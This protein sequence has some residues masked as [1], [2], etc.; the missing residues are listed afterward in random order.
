M[1]WLLISNYW[2]QSGY[3]IYDL[4]RDVAEGLEE[5]NFSYGET[6]ALSAKL[7]LQQ[8]DLKPG[9]V[10][11]DLGSGRGIF[12]FSSYFLHNLRGV[13][14]ELFQT[15]INKS[16]KIRNAMKVAGITFRQGNI[17][18]ADISDADMVY[19]A[20]TT[21]QKDVLEKVIENLKNTAPDTIIIFIHH[22]LPEDDFVLFDQGNYPF[23][24][25]TDQVYFYRRK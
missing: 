9:S 1:Q 3:R 6:T 22:K 18:D 10:I 16:V 23:S 7:I 4:E 5:E 11:Y 8:L 2:G 20:G 13:G 17:T 12:L 21:Y 15:Y 19:V 24:W 25:G 14:V